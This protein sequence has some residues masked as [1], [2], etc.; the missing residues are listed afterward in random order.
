M[1]VALVIVGLVWIIL[2]AAL[3]LYTQETKTFLERLIRKDKAR[4]WA[5]LPLLM[6][7]ILM[8]GAFTF[9]E[10]YGVAF[11]LGFLAFLKGLFLAFAPSAY[12][13]GLF[14]WWQ[15]VGAGTVRLF[16]LLAFLLGS[17]VLSYA[18]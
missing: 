15:K 5:I 4:V 6:G 18:L 9:V 16:G 12:I 3:V 1:V 2:G 13:H 17:A 10:T 14:D 11:V 7:V 8:I